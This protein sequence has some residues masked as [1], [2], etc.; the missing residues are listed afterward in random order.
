MGWE[1]PV[2]SEYPVERDFQADRIEAWNA[3]IEKSCLNPNFVPYVTRETRRHTVLRSVRC[4]K[5]VK[6]LKV[7]QGQWA[8]R[9]TVEYL[10]AKRTWW[11]TLSYRGKHEP[12][13]EDVKRFYKRLRKKEGGRG[14]RYV[15]SEERG[16]KNDRLHWHILLHCQPSL[17]RRQIERSWDF[18]YVHAR[19]AKTAGLG[20]YL[21][22]YLAKQSRIRASV[23]YGGEETVSGLFSKSEWEDFQSYIT[24]GNQPSRP[25]FARWITPGGIA[26]PL[27]DI[28]SAIERANCVNLEGTGIV[29]F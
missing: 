14:L 8:Y 2:L 29:P 10:A 7:R 13:Y 24:T 5:C 28:Y 15:V 20:G 26:I 9:A 19:L 6:C 25:E 4:R 23:S 1:L 12:D 21:A 11:L 18:G 27:P 22:K 16:G 3:R 17:T